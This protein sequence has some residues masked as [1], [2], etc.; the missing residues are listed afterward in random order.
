MPKMPRNP[1]G[2]E[3]M[4]ALMDYR[5]YSMSP[6]ALYDYVFE[7]AVYNRFEQGLAQKIN[8]NHPE[9]LAKLGALFKTYSKIPVP[10]G[11]EGIFL[12]A[13]FA[14]YNAE[15]RNVAAVR[16]RREALNVGTTRLLGIAAVVAQGLPENGQ[17][18]FLS[19]PLGQKAQRL[20]E[21]G[22]SS[23]QRQSKTS[24]FVL[25]LSDAY[26]AP[27]A[28]NQPEPLLKLSAFFPEDPRLSGAALRQMGEPERCEV[29][30]AG[31]LRLVKEGETAMQDPSRKA[32]MLSPLL[33]DVRSHA[34]AENFVLESAGA[35]AA[36]R[37][38]EASGAQRED[39]LLDAIGFRIA[40]ELLFRLS[41]GDPGPT[42]AGS[43]VA[44]R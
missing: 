21:L 18:E 16:E 24:A 26:Q 22:E 37:F 41:M 13:E 12:R 14:A 42:G 2:P 17:L 38:R 10:S 11:F 32:A 8:A 36:N 27:P 29:L 5:A 15:L 20:F 23:L 44:A 28:L 35:E 3:D 25:S 7:Q 39:I 31:V 40:S 43:G 33:S 30:T 6:T 19:A 1:Q 4:A 34:T 9:D